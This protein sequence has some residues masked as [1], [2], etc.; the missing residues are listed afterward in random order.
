[1]SGH[2]FSTSVRIIIEKNHIMGSGH[3]EDV[4]VDAANA[5]NH[6]TTIEDYLPKDGVSWLRKPHLLKLNLL[7]S[8][9]MLAS[10]NNGYDGSML[11]GLQSMTTWQEYFGHPTGHHLG[12]LSN[13]YLFGAVAAWPFAP[14]LADRFGR[15][16]PIAFGCMVIIVGAV[17][18]C[19]AQNYAMFLIGRL[20]IG[21]GAAFCVLAS[22]MLLSE[23]TFPTHRHIMTAMYNTLWYLGAII[24]A[25]LTIGTNY[26][27]NDW[28][29]RIPSLCQAAMPV[30]QLAMIYFVPESPRY[31][32][33]KERYEE[34][35]KVL[36]K[37]HAGGDTESRLVDFEMAEITAQIGMERD[38]KKAQY[39]EFFRTAPNRKRLFLIVMISANMQ[40]SGNGLVSYYLNLVLNSIGITDSQEQLY[41]NGGLMIYNW[42]F[43]MMFASLVERL[44]RRPLFLFSFAGM[45]T[46]Y[47]I[48][49]VLSAINQQRN[50]EDTSLGKGVLAMIFLYYFCYGAGLNGLPILY[51]TEIVPYNLRA[52]GM[53]IHA[54]TD[55]LVLI[56]N[57]FVNPVAMEAIQWKYY[58]VWDCVLAV[59]LAIAYFF[60]PETKGHTLETVGQV[61]GEEVAQVDDAVVEHV[62]QEK[63]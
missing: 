54:V 14:W 13:G 27:Q 28:A 31:L 18:Q 61:F 17:I 1:M 2:Q 42:I 4:E 49:T 34:A 22:P 50:F 43:A 24:A 62:H 59:E 53:N 15:K 63:V 33:Y 38:Q 8:V 11:N 51:F 41:I 58:I 21:F 5:E 32:I 23:L 60:Y 26:I 16:I 55:K 47:I 20:L 19:A 10:T 40:M 12:G 48:W 35:R 36:V 30:I 52:K 25:W 44:G 45:L 9:C 3:V 37:F 46:T 56:Y 29:W 7:L 57:G 39:M 6:H